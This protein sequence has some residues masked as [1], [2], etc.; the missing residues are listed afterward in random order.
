MDIFI[1]KKTKDEFKAILSPKVTGTINLDTAI[2]DMALD[3]FILFSS[4]AGA[5][6]NAGQTDYSTANAFMDRLE[7]YQ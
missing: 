3:F 6:G 2:K 7:S 4:G 5:M 1:I